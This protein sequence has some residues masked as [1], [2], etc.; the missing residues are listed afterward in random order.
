MAS[1]N[2]GPGIFALSAIILAV[3][4][5]NVLNKREDF[6]ETEIDK[7]SSGPSLQDSQKLEN[8]QNSVV[9]NIGTSPDQVNK[10][11]AQY[12]ANL[13]NY[14]NPSLGNL[15][16]AQNISSLPIMGGKNLPGASS[17]YTNVNGN[18]YVDNLG[19]LDGSAFPPVAY[20]N[21]RA[22]QLSKCAKDLP[23]F[24]ASSL[25]PKPSAN[26]DN[27]A[28]SQ[29]AARALAAFTAL[30]PVEQIGAITSIN[31]PYSKTSDIRAL[32]QIPISS[33]QTALFNTSPSTYV[34]PTYGQVNN[35][36][37]KAG[38]SGYTNTAYQ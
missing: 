33:M 4:A 23:M 30:S 12:Y 32:D 14:L 10:M 29:S 27:N 21:D 19:Y 8:Y 34:S 28:L 36:T 38:P 31:T 11:G 18:G 26:A 17:S 22:S 25:L 2:L 35:L 7:Y 24:A 16:L 20:S 13:Q 3:S 1:E 15:Q 5:F 6:T 9:L 37:D